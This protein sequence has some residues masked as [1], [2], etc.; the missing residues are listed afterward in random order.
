MIVLI[1][2]ELRRLI[3][4][5]LL[6]Y[7]NILPVLILMNLKK[8][9]SIHL[10]YKTKNQTSVFKCMHH[11]RVYLSLIIKTIIDLFILINIQKA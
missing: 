10:I 6:P 4:I 5:L 11:L 9:L 3:Y 8:P 7:Y 2:Y 1:I